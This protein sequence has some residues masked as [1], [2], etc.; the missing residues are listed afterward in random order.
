MSITKQ[1]FGKMPDGTPID[2]YTLTNTNGL[3]VKI[4][5]YGGV[6]VS[7]I[8]PDQHGQLGDV[9]LGFDTLEQY[10]EQSPFFGCII[11]RYVNRIAKAKF[12]LDG[13]EYAL[14]Q[15]D[16]E[17]H[18]HGGIKGFDKQVWDAI[19]VKNDDGVG[20]KLSYL[21]PDGEENRLVKIVYGNIKVF[22]S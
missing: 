6:I 13:I 16:G 12:I 15:N 1:A 14:A 2:L 4:T 22:N 19:A 3:E 18:L 8:T 11:G 20:V 10:I 7:I 9:V 21:S 17:N 5:N